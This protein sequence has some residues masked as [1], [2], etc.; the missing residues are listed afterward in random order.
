MLLNGIAVKVP[1]KYLYLCTQTWDVF[2]LGQRGF[3]VWWAIVNGE[4]GNHAK[5]KSKIQS[6]RPEQT[7]ISASHHEGSEYLRRGERRA[8][9]SWRLG[10]SDVKCPLL[11][12][13]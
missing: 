1:Y 9:K 12:M 4:I 10:R 6:T 7:F 2:N 11:D 13:A 3:L 5:S 8:C